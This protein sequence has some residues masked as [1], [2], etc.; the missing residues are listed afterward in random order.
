MMRF[1]PIL[2]GLAACAST[3]LTGEPSSTRRSQAAG[4]F[5]SA[6]E[7]SFAGPASPIRLSTA[8]AFWDEAGVG[9]SQSTVGACTVRACAPPPATRTPSSGDLRIA[10]GAAPLTLSVDANGRYPNPAGTVSL[11]AAET[12]IRFTSPGGDVPALDVT[13]AAPAPLQ[14]LEPEPLGAPIAI[15]RASGL[16]ARWEPGDGEVRVA[17]RQETNDGASAFDGGVAIDCFYDRSAGVASVP[18]AA[19]SG[20]SAGDAHAMVYSTRRTRVAAGHYD[21]LVLVNTAGVFRRATI[22]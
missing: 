1:V 20:L 12:P 2:V 11:W 19:L 16:R 6:T 17:L 18:A 13:L 9:C 5:V 3:A 10:F 8:V 15:D 14:V 4:G 7:A 22:R 21:V